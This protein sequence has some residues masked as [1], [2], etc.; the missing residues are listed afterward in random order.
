[1]LKV[2]EFLRNILVDGHLNVHRRLMPVAFAIPGLRK[3]TADF[4]SKRIRV[5]GQN[6]VAES[7]IE[8]T[9]S[10]PAAFFVKFLLFFLRLE[11]EP[12]VFAQ[13]N[14]SLELINELFSTHQF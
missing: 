5:V 14:F 1:M 9:L 4:L 6:A 12:T 10:R 13:H 11:L 3:V 2:L 8:S 7:T